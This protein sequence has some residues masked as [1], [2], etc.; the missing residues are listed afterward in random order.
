M[1][2]EQ[3]IKQ[4]GSQRAFAKAVGIS[5][6]QVNRVVKGHRE[7]GPAMAVSIYKA[8]GHKLGPLADGRCYTWRTCAKMW[9]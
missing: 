3:L 2:I 8:T 5:V 9:Y 4:Y 7:L 6:Q 1:P